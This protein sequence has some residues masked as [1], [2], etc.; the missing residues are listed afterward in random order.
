VTWL[1]NANVL[2]ALCTP[3]HVDHTRAWN[4]CCSID[5]TSAM[6]LLR[7]WTVFFAQ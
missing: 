1:L 4:W 5:A 3:D 2:I 7:Q 6:K